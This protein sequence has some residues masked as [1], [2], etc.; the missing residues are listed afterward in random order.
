MK[1]IFFFVEHWSEMLQHDGVIGTFSPHAF[2]LQ[3]HQD[4]KCEHIV[5]GVCD[6][7]KVCKVQLQHLA[8]DVRTRFQSVMALIRASCWR[9]DQ[10]WNQNLALG[11][12]VTPWHVFFF[13][14]KT[15]LGELTVMMML[16]SRLQNCGI[17]LFRLERFDIHPNICF[18]FC[19]SLWGTKKLILKL[20]KTTY[21]KHF[22][23]NEK[24][25]STNNP[26]LKSK[27]S[28]LIKV[29]LR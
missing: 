19:L 4:D 29:K 16:T 8:A 27:E 26:V 10:G 25:I 3:M 11:L 7:V 1:K 21:E 5:A 14:R 12:R 23:Q 18:L 6:G 20:I 15:F 24:L 28:S 13:L 17:K 2:D 22:L 9:R